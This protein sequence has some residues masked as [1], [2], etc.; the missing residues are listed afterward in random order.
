M[1]M[2][3]YISRIIKN[4][5]WWISHCHRSSDAPNLAMLNTLLHGLAANSQWLQVTVDVG[6]G[7]DV[8]LK[9][10]PFLGNSNGASDGYLDIHDIS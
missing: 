1:Y 9:F 4:H 3:R 10:H 7:H 5:D 6:H 8:P 2:Y